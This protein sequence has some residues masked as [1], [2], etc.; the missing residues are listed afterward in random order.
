VRSS[1]E[2]LHNTVRQRGNEKQPGAH[3]IVVFN[4]AIEEHPWHG[5]AAAGEIRI[6]VHPFTHFDT[7]G[8]IDIAG[9]ERE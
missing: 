6:V 4:K 9:K 8:R 2:C 1:R 5:D 7:S 3:A